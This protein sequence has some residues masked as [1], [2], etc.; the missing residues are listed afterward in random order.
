MRKN[1]KKNSKIFGK[2][3]PRPH[4]ILFEP[5]EPL[6][7]NLN[8]KELF[9]SRLARVNASTCLRAKMGILEE[10][11]KHVINRL[12][13]DPD[14]LYDDSKSSDQS[15]S[16]SREPAEGDENVDALALDTTK[17]CTNG[18]PYLVKTYKGRV[19][20]EPIKED[21]MKLGHGLFNRKIP[22]KNYSTRGSRYGTH[23]SIRCRDY[24]ESASSCPCTIKIVRTNTKDDGG[25]DE[26]NVYMTADHNHKTMAVPKRGLDFVF[27]QNTTQRTR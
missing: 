5:T 2:I 8:K 17:R 19:E 25:L 10:I 7:Q 27:F 6:R 20:T 3:I 26:T 24:R 16:S 9:S 13:I 4:Y 22:E 14:K 15:K 12:N 11:A 1:E 21:L 18:H 23:E